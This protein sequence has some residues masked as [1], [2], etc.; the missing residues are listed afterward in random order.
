MKKIDI[1]TCFGLGKVAHARVREGDTRLA[2]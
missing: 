1:F 2:R